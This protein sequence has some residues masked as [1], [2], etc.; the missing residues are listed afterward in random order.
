MAKILSFNNANASEFIASEEVYLQTG[1]HD[2]LDINNM[3]KALGSEV[4]ERYYSEPKNE[5]SVFEDALLYAE[6]TRD[7]IRHDIVGS[8]EEREENESRFNQV[9]EAILWARNNKDYSKLI[10]F[11]KADIDHIAKT[12]IIDIP[13]EISIKILINLGKSLELSRNNK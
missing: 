8:N 2:K 10:E 9:N 4:L 6:N 1:P 11:I 5:E 13:K 12:M 3:A 7:N